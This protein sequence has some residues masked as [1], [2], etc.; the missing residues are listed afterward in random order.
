[1]S[2]TKRAGCANGRKYSSIFE[3][4]VQAG[5]TDT[6]VISFSSGGDDKW[7][8]LNII[9]DALIEYLKGNLKPKDVQG[10]VEAA[11]SGTYE[12]AA[13]ELLKV[14]K[15][16]NIAVRACV[17]ERV[18][19]DLAT[20]P[21]PKIITLGDESCTVRCDCCFIDEKSHDIDVV[22]YQCTAP[23]FTRTGKNRIVDYIPIY[24]L[25]MYGRAIA[26]EKFGENAN[27]HIS[28]SIVYLKTGNDASVNR[29]SDL[30]STCYIS[31]SEESVWRNLSGD[32]QKKVGRNWSDAVKSKLNELLD[33]FAEGYECDGKECDNCK[34]KMI[35][36]FTLPPAEAPEKKIKE[37]KAVE[38]STSQQSVVD[39]IKS[40]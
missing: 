36:K 2:Y 32:K 1:M 35:C 19:K 18:R 17:S 38:L 20:F 15:I 7:N 25:L 21:E 22:L 33:E 27:A 8:E 13:Q 23:K 30:P 40:L 37:R 12:S 6:P 34:Y 9:K 16:S 26:D 28:A 11:I 29:L 24:W 10:E 14:L 31:I 39:W 3:P 4:N 5:T